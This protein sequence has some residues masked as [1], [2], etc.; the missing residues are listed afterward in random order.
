M[1]KHFDRLVRDGAITIDPDPAL[2]AEVLSVGP[3]GDMT[4]TS[5]TLPLFQG[6]STFSFFLR[7]IPPAPSWHTLFLESGLSMALSRFKKS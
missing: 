3:S 5:S 2:R 6:S 4:P 1:K 7:S